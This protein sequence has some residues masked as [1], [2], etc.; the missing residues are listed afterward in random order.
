MA[1]AIDQPLAARVSSAA[2]GAAPPTAHSGCVC[3]TWPNRPEGL[4]FWMPFTLLLGTM[5]ALCWWRILRGHHPESGSH[6]RKLR[7]GWLVGA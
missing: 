2:A 6:P 3:V 4:I 1:D 7:G 5:S